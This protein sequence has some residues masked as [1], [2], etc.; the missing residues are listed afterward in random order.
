MRLLYFRPINNADGEEY[1]A[2]VVQRGDP[3]LKDRPMSSA[4]VAPE[5][6]RRD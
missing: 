4:E 2:S 5:L 1:A 6:V 3:R